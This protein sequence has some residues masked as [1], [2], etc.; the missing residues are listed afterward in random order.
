MKCSELM[1]ILKRDGWFPFS[2]KGSHI[3]L[4]HP[5]KTGV[6]IFPDHGSNEIE[7]VYLDLC[8]T[9]GREV[10]V[11]YADGHSEIGPA[12]SISPNGELVL[13]NGVHVLAADIIHL[14]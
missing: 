2:K 3:K 8:A 4:K 6:L 10:R 1:R 12:V 9:I 14:R 11:E 5:T 13:A 7:A